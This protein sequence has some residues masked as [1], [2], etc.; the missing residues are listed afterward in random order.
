VVDVIMLEFDK[1]TTGLSK[2]LFVKALNAEGIPCL[3]GYD[4]PLN[5]HPV[6]NSPLIQRCPVGCPYHGKAIDYAGQRFPVSQYACESSIWI[7]HYAILLGDQKDM[8]DVAAAIG[9]IV[10]NAKAL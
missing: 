3:G 10:Q 7:W 9:K 4:F 1:Q 8:D 6:M 2:N 5:E